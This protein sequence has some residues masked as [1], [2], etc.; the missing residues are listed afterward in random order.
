[1]RTLI[2][3]TASL[4]SGPAWTADFYAIVDN[5]GKRPLNAY[6]DV[7]VD[8]ASGGNAAPEVLFT[9]Y[10][11]QGS[12]IAEF[13]VPANVGFASTFSSGNLFDLTN[14]QRLLVRAR[15]S[16]IAADHG[17]AL[18]LEL[19]GAHVILGV[20]QKSKTDGSPDG[21]GNLFAVPLGSFKK[22]SL[23]IANVA[24]TDVGVESFRGV[25]NAPGSGRS[26]NERLTS[27]ASFA[28][29]LT[30]ADAF[31]NYI[32]SST[33]LIIVQV[34]IDDG[35]TVHSYMVPPVH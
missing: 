25:K 3:I 13:S 23:L 31:S 7:A 24:G 32:V 34:V 6:L 14:G 10:D 9:A 20:L 15:T 8:Q 2:V 1:M 26:L 5:L 19:R 12:Q 11:V 22:A 30:Q 21:S 35:K 16:S 28:V 18:Q 4:L 17:A 27:H 33:G 29:D